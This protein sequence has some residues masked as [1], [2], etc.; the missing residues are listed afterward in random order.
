MRGEQDGRTVLTLDAGGTTSTFSA[1]RGGREVV[2]PFTWPAQAQDLDRCLDQYVAGF[3]RA[4]AEAGGCDAI[5]FGFPGPADYRHGIIGALANM[6]A[7]REPVPLGPLLEA[8]F[9]CP[10]F[11]HND[12]DLFAYGEAVGGFLPEVN[13]AL[14]AT[15]SERR[16]HNLIGLTLGTGF[17]CGLVRK[18]ELVVGDN[19]AAGE[20]WLLRHPEMRHVFAEEGVSIRAVRRVYAELAGVAWGDVPEPKALA[21]IAR[22]QGPGHRE[23]ALEAFARLGRVAGDA[24]ATVLTLFDGLAVLGGGLSGAADLFM[25]ALLAELNGQLQNLEGRRFPRLEG[26]V[27]AW[28]D[29]ADRAAF[30][31]SRTVLLPVPGTGRHVPYEPVKRTAVGLT[32]LGTSR[33]TALGAW[34]LALDALDRG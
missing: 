26:H 27:H 32:R 31:A 13:A 24:L 30:L 21:D 29:G 34:A 33:A 7:F 18:G 8:R 22:G 23:A 28:G 20:I 6:P 19:G 9:Q 1:L 25:P 4:K 12:G 10:V 15:G 2:T 14:E 5:S 11:I 3:Q 16:H 17:G